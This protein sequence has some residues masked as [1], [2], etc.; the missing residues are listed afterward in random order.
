VRA[1]IEDVCGA[2]VVE[3][4]TQPG[5][6]SPGLAARVRCADGAHQ[7]DPHVVLQD[8]EGSCVLR[9][10]LRKRGVTDLL[11]EPFRL[12]GWIEMEDV[13]R[14]PEVTGQRLQLGQRDSRLS[15]T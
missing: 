2:G 15:L 7:V 4:R 10:R 1:A 11:G 3:A 9:V 12:K 5:G 14:R 6:F 13:V 8:P